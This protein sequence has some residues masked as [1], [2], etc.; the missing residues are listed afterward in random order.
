ME[1][2][3]SQTFSS[4]ELIA[5]D[6]GSVDDTGEILSRYASTDSR[7]R[8]IRHH[9]RGLA[10]SLNAGIAEAVGD[11]IARL[12][13]DDVPMPHRVAT[14]VSWMNDHP[15]YALV[16]STALYLADKGKTNTLKA[17]PT[18]HAAVRRLL[19]RG[20]CLIH[21]TVMMR[22]A[23]FIA[24]GGYR[25]C[26]A[27]AQDY[28]LWLRM[29]EHGLIANIA[30]PLI[31]YRIHSEQATVRKLQQQVW[32]TLAAQYSAFRRREGLAD[33]LEAVSKIDDSI[34]RQFG[35]GNNATRAL[36]AAFEDRVATHLSVYQ[37]SQ[38]L[39]YADLIRA[40][41][42]HPKWVRLFKPRL[43]WQLALDAMRHGNTIVAGKH[44]V[45]AIYWQP[46][47]IVRFPIRLLEAIGIAGGA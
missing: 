13:A 30:E 18:D 22:K 21:P 8:V 32:G 28:D 11:Y 16:G 25:E 5:V 7:I 39:Q 23:T 37:R 9:N 29:I 36:A 33:P 46:S 17:V 47:L 45:Q 3:L 31:Y 27:A 38:A 35:L 14:Q 6:D 41:A 19:L 40:T 12:D 44:A 34:I 15:E 43:D 24:A 10:A 42:D 20:N 1:G 2:V 4:W 26:F